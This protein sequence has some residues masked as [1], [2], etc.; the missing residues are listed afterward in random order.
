V[1]VLS[2]PLGGENILGAW[3]TTRTQFTDQ[4][5]LLFVHAFVGAG[6]GPGTPAQQA[7][8]SA[9]LDLGGLPFAAQP[10]LLTSVGLPS[11]AVATG[12][13][14]PGPLLAKGP[15]YAAAR[16]LAALPVAARQ[17]WLA[18]HLA[19]LRSGRLTLAQLP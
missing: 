7:V 1:P 13:P 4:L 14:T 5:R 6:I 11:W 8:Q 10:K 15:I 3:G 2:V 19:A 9:L 12:G 16:R 18:S 17:A